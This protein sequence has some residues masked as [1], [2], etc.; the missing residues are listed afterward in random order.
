MM[1]EFTS[2]VWVEPTEWFEIYS[3]DLQHS[4]R[5][6]VQFICVLLFKII[7]VLRNR[8]RNSAWWSFNFW[9]T[10][11]FMSYWGR[12]CWSDGSQE[13]AYCWSIDDMETWSSSISFWNIQLQPKK[14]T[15]FVHLRS[16]ID[17][18]RIRKAENEPATRNW[19]RLGEF[20]NNWRVTRCCIH[21]CQAWEKKRSR[22]RVK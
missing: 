1:R 12:W 14:C 6:T 17:L 21:F 5:H 16:V 9:I 18:E 20:G 8:V 4:M 15:F 7:T 10:D 2:L 11:C 13:S 19:H 3:V 22:E